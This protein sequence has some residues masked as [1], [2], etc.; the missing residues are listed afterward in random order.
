MSCPA[1]LFRARSPT[2]PSS[3]QSL[4]QE[5]QK[6]VTQ[7]KV[8]KTPPATLFCYG[9]GSIRSASSVQFYKGG[10][11]K[12][13]GS[14]VNRDLLQKRGVHY[15]KGYGFYVLPHSPGNA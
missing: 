15:R 9:F 4:D 7:I 5:S 6:L 14:L 10:F 12:L 2:L 13:D 11:V 8:T 3:E 1:I